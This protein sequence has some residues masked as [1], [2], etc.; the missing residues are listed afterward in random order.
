MSA[1]SVLLHLLVETCMQSFSCNR[2]FVRIVCVNLGAPRL[3]VLTLTDSLY[4]CGIWSQY[5]LYDF[6]QQED[7]YRVSQEEMSVLWEAIVSVILSKIVYI[8]NG[9]RD[10]A[11]SLYRSLNLA[12]NIVHHSRHTAPLYEAM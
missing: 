2:Q 7:L 10:R 1:T 12:P 3:I 11:I 8:L 4:C 6:H 5:V 9:F